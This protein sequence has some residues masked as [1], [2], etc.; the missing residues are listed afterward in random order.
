MCIAVQ[1]RQYDIEQAYEN[2]PAFLFTIKP[3]LNLYNNRSGVLTIFAA[4]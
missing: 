4:T 2:K 3:L 1:I